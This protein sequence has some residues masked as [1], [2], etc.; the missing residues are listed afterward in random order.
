MANIIFE[1]PR[2]FDGIPIEDVF[3]KSREIFLTEEVNAATMDDLIKQVIYLE[4]EDDSKEITFY[5]NSP[6]GSVSSGLA[7]YD[8]L[9]H[10]KCPIRTVCIGTAA[11]MGAILFLAGDKREIMEHGKIMIHDPSFGKMEVGGMKPHEIQQHVDSL[12]E[13]RES[14]AR[15]ISKRTGKT[16]KEVYKVTANDTYYNAEAALKFGLATNIISD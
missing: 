16:M 14:I 2:G 10:A 8:V 4:R 1:S 11:S 5:I 12:N 9:M 15:I 6:G 13:T 7:L 3:L